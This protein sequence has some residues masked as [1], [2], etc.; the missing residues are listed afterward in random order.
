MWY[1]YMITTFMSKVRLNLYNNYTKIR[2]LLLTTR[3]LSYNI[4]MNYNV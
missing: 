1:P 2:Q 4:C 3:V